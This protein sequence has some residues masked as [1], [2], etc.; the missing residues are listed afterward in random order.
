M[1]PLSIKAEA[2]LLITSVYV[3][4]AQLQHWERSATEP[5]HIY[6]QYGVIIRQRLS[7]RHQKHVQYELVQSTLEHQREKL[8][9]LEKAEK[10]SRRLEEALESGGR[11]LTASGV[12]SAPAQGQSVLT[13]QSVI[14]GSLYREPGQGLSDDPPAGLPRTPTKRKG[15]GG[16]YGLLSAVKHSLSGMMD[17]DPEAT[18]RANIGRTR[19]NI[20]QVGVDTKYEPVD[21]LDL[22]P[23]IR[24]QLED[25]LQA[26]AQDLKYASQTLQAD[27][28]R[29]QR[30][31]VAD[32]RDMTLAIAELHREWAKAVSAGIRRRALVLKLIYRTNHA[33]LESLGGSQ[34]GHPGY[35][36]S[37]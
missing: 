34:A 35:R 27:L 3:L 5:L 21:R 23:L 15:G 6:A 14:G 16:G 24:S 30:Q 11:N 18:R 9:V 36:T 8:E 1:R 33:E 29:F 17:V 37:S 28:D 32:M 31:K 12:G 10:E 19:D 7:F 25:S 2:Q 13:G 22:T 4:G 26:A 20:S